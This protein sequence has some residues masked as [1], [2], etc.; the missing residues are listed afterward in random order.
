LTVVVIL[1]PLTRVSWFCRTK[2]KKT[3]VNCKVLKRCY[4]NLTE[5]NKRL[6]K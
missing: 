5:E 4:E 3:K 1:Q 6:Q 2:L